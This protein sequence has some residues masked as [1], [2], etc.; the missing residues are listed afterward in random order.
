[1]TI[2]NPSRYPDSTVR[3]LRPWLQAALDQVAPARGDF[4]VRFVNDRKMRQLNS[5]YR[6]RDSTTDVLSFPGDA[7]ALGPHLGDVV[8]SVP[9]AR[10]QAVVAGHPVQRELRLLILHGI[11]HC[12]GHD[13]ETDDGQMEQAEGRWR[14]RLL[15]G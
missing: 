5:T 6:Q 15:D 14:Q 2:Q 1:M 8:I 4:T 11:L 7:S 9:V 3:Q 10:R 12:L 13:H